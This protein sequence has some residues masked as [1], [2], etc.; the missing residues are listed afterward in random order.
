MS[1]RGGVCLSP[2]PTH[3]HTTHA[4]TTTTTHHNRQR[5]LQ[6]AIEEGGGME[7]AGEVAGE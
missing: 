2:F 1:G 5:R 7:L 4:H 3:T 6:A